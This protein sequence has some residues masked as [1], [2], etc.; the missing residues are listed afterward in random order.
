VLSPARALEVFALLAPSAASGADAAAAARFLDEYADRVQVA[1]ILQGPN[2]AALKPIVSGV[3]KA[4]LPAQLAFDIV[5]AHQ[6]FI[7]GLS[8]LLEVDT[9]LDPPVPPAPLTLNQSVV[10]RDAVVRDPAALR[11]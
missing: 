5:L 4:E 2:A 6:R 11:Q 8:P 7:L 9:F 1:A 3:L 10:G